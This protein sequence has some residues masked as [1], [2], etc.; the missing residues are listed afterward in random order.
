MSDYDLPDLPSDEELGITEEDHQK[1]GEDLP[2]DGPE[3]S[4]KEMAALLG[5]STKSP[6]QGTSKGRAPRSAADSDA[7][8][9]EKAAA[10]EAKK[11]AKQEKKAAKAA[12]KE[13]RKAG[14]S[15]TGGG[16]AKAGRDDGSPPGPPAAVGEPSTAAASRSSWR[17]LVTL[18]VLV[19]TAAL[20]S[21][22]TGMPRPVPADAP[23][24]TFS[25]ARAM[26][27]V[28]DMAREPH[29]TGSPEH[30]RVRDLLLERMRAMGLDPEVQETTTLLESDQG[31]RA[32]TVRNIVARIPGIAPTGTVLITSHYDSRAGATGAADAAAATAAI[33]EAVRALQART[34]T[35]NDVVVLITDAEELGLLGARAF[36][37]E[38]PLMDE[39]DLALGFEMRGSGGVSI[40]FETNELNG[41]VV[42]AMEEWD[43]PPYTN[44]MSYEIYR[45]MPN[46]TDFTV[47]REAGVQGLNFAAIDRAQAYHQRYDTPGRLSETTLQDHG[48][49]ALEALRYFGDADLGAV[50]TTN[51]VYVTLPFLGLVV[52][53]RVWV[54]PISGLIVLLFALLV[55]LAHRRGASL[56]AVLGALAV[57]LVAAGMGFGLARGLLT[58]LPGFHDEAGAL[59]GAWVHGEGWYVLA[60]AFGAL[61][62][63]AALVTLF[64][65]WVS[66]LEMSMGALILPVLAAIYLSFFSPLAAMNLQWPVLAATVAA[67]VVVLTGKGSESV[68]GWLVAVAL[69]VPTVVFLTPVIELVWLGLTLRLA[70]VLA[71]GACVALLLCVPAL[72][73]L[74][75]P[76]GWWA[77]TT[78]AAL[79]A[80][81]T[82]V[83]LL[84]ANPSADRPAPSTLAYAYEHGT[85]DAV[86]ISDDVADPLTDPG[87]N[88]AVQQ[89]GATFEERRDLTDFGYPFGEVATTPGPVVDIPRPEVDIV[90]DSIFADTR[91][92]A[93]RVR[94]RIQAEVMEF[95]LDGL[96]R[97]TAI[98]GVAV[99]DPAAL[100]NIDHW[101]VPPD[102]GVLLELTMP[103]DAPIGMHIVERHFRPE[104]LLGAT[105][106]QRPDYLAPNVMRLS[107]QAMLRFSVADLADP[108]FSMVPTTTDSLASSTPADSLLAPLDTAVAAP[109]DTGSL[110]PSDTTDLTLQADS[111]SAVVPLDS[112][113]STPD[114]LPRDTLP[115]DDTLPRGTPQDTPQGDTG[116]R[117]HGES[118]S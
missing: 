89:A 24:T 5:G 26:S 117:E 51:V 35:R 3:M 30:T 106:F 32:A 88:W 52:Y 42:R 83:G 31:A 19:A 28:T 29:P 11:R 116:Q 59:A 58:L 74:R 73:G 99:S 97:L 45:R 69:A 27:L 53:E 63:V 39:V 66:L 50:N 40:M 37:A 44:S 49:H 107:D 14:K 34:E 110:P 21:T 68:V 92:V 6:A 103:P 105:R 112:A 114:T 48:I 4:E 56:M 36:A 64:R 84:S 1:Y 100:Q 16:G 93:M 15:A 91:R 46:N 86:W 22:R 95:R 61:A 70:G 77:P 71:A 54:L 17:G 9:R 13:A 85:G 102:G 55:V 96:T 104:T 57:S 12:K 87:H 98:N 75:H 60:L 90:G 78:A 23:D 109:T 72:A 67:L 20:S 101:G 25:S 79:A 8:K 43:D 2:D 94:S 41:W 82:G 65:P 76:N 10:K 115:G 108:R 7:S 80:L 118:M 47:F 18:A 111:A 62:I 33:L 113:G 81:F 38:H